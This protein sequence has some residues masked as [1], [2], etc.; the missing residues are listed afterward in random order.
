MESHNHLAQEIASR[1]TEL[2]GLRDKDQHLEQ[3]QAKK[4]A[5]LDA[6]TFERST[7]VNRIEELERAL[8]PLEQAQA[9]LA[10]QPTPQPADE[11]CHVDP[12]DKEK[13]EVDNPGGSKKDVGQR[14]A[15]TDAEQD[16]MRNWKPGEKTNDDAIDIVRMVL[17]DHGEV[18]QWEIAQRMREVTGWKMGTCYGYTSGAMYSL[19]HHGEVVWTGE[20]EVL[21]SKRTSVVWRLTTEEERAQLDPHV[22]VAS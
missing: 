2:T 11:A 9:I 13:R 6:I 10:H 21:E 16:K 17:G 18:C 22:E 14:I 4:K 8:I 15:M 19:R 1:K 5:E 20:K 7:V 12:T 3:R